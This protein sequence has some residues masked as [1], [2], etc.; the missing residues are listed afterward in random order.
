M[1][2]P[3]SI[4]TPP[5]DIQEFTDL[6][7]ATGAHEGVPD[8]IYTTFWKFYSNGEAYFAQIFKPRLDIS[9][10]EV[11]EA[12]RRVPDADI[13]PEIREA[14]N[15]KVVTTTSEPDTELYV[16]RPSLLTYET[17]HPLDLVRDVFLGEA[18]IMEQ[19]SSINHKN[20]VRYHGCQVR[21]GRLTGIVLQRHECS[22]FEYFLWGRDKDVALDSRRFMEELESAVSHLHQAG[23]A[24]NDLKPSNI[25]L[26]KEQMPVL[27]DFGSCRPFGARL[28]EGGT[29]GWS[30]SERLVVSSDKEHDL[31]SLRRIREWLAN[32]D[33][34]MNG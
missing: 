29:P 25:L 16:K 12:L 1:A 5:H 7:G 19:V 32:P 33:R 8:G 2:A 26:D 9:L 22:L 24:H 14:A 6:D 17:S 18:E 27:I 34:E 21:D 28:M 15:L 23:L 4:I 30:N 31:F 10:A 11:R 13:Y 3:N 20:I